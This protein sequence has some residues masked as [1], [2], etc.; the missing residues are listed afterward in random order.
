M[1]LLYANVPAFLLILCRI[2]SFF[3]TAPV[4]SSRNVPPM[5]KLGLA[6]YVSLIVFAALGRQSPAEI[7]AL[8]VLSILKEILTG[9]VI[10]F[11]ANLFFMAVQMAGGLIDIQLGFGM[12]NLIDPVTGTSAP[13]TGNLKFMLAMLLLFSFNGH[14]YLLQAIMAS[15]DWLPLDNSLWTRLYSGQMTEFLTRSF[16]T[17]LSLAFQLAAP[18]VVSLFLVDIG[19]GILAKTAPQF[20]LFVVGLPVK[21]AVG[22]LILLLLIPDY[23]GLYH[24]LFDRMF[25]AVRDLMRVLAGRPGTS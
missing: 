18:L 20:N 8:Y 17:V 12:A 13:L 2:T 10:G 9:V 3:L 4:F 14:Y 1:E 19:L 5:I 25:A 22:L 24:D 7:D 11:T 15:Y 6:F 23:G 16:G 21:I